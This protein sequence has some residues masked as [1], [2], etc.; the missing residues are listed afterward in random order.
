MFSWPDMLQCQ[1]DQGIY[2]TK[3]LTM[4]TKLYWQG[5]KKKH[6]YLKKHMQRNMETFRLR[7]LKVTYKICKDKDSK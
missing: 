2:K 1:R 7:F 3:K 4:K 5:K 6:I